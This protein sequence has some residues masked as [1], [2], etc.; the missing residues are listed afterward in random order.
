MSMRGYAKLSPYGD[1][2][3]V[4]TLV[5]IQGFV[6]QQYQGSQTLMA[7]VTP[8]DQTGFIAVPHWKVRLAKPGE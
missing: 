2:T 5:A 3:D 6:S 7:V 1:E 8:R 4:E